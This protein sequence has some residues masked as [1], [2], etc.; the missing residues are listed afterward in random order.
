[1]RVD[2]IGIDMRLFWSKTAYFIDL[3]KKEMNESDTEL[4]RYMSRL[5][6]YPR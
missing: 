1:V 2:S 4:N 5:R 6:G 3:D